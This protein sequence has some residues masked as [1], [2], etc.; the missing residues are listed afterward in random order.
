MQALLSNKCI[1]YVSHDEG[2]DGQTGEIGFL[3]GEIFDGEIYNDQPKGWGKLTLTDGSYYEGLFDTSGIVE[4][5][6]V[7]FSR[8]CF[9]GRFLRDRFESGS[10]HF[11]DGDVLKG[12]WGNERGKWVMKKGELYNEDNLHV[13]NF[14]RESDR[15]DYKS[16]GKEVFKFDSVLGF[17]VKYENCLVPDKSTIKNLCFTAEGMT[18]YEIHQSGILTERITSKFTSQLPYIKTEKI[19]HNKTIKNLYNFC[20]GFTVETDEHNYTAKITFKDLDNISAE[21]QFEMEKVTFK[22]IGEI[23]YKNTSI[24]NLNIK[25]GNFGGLKLKMDDNDFNTVNIFYNYIGDYCATNFND[26]TVYAGDRPVVR[27]NSR[28]SA[29]VMKDMITDIK[30]QSNCVIM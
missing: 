15:V 10:L 29:E 6:F 17:C 19:L 26:V 28:R 9:E 16:K 18:Q 12:E 13:G 24:G 27:K 1:K 11:C 8:D 30:E 2:S 21:G 5:K 23:K 4:G 3:N 7:H 25:K 14:N 22:F 20:F